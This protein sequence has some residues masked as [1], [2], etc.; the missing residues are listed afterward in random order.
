MPKK[1]PNPGLCQLC[2]HHVAI[3]QRAHIVAEAGRT[4]ANLPMLCRLCRARHN[5]HLS[6][7]FFA[8]VSPPRASGTTW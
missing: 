8:V 6:V 4:P 7:R 5:L 2:G 1:G 3:R